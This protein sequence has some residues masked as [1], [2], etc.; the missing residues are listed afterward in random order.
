[1]AGSFLL[2]FNH[3]PTSLQQEDAR[4]SLGV[5]EIIRFPEFLWPVWNAVPPE[6]EK[7]ESYLE[8]IRAWVAATAQPGDYILIQGDFGATYLMVKFAFERGL[9]PVYSTT[10]RVAEEEHGADG[11]VRLVHKF[12]H[13]RYRIY[14]V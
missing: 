4:L 5:G 7:I 3:T 14:G 1:M 8:T 12:R 6:L 9:I 13:V 10:E 11:S 2:L